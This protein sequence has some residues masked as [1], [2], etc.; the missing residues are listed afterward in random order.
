MPVSWRHRAAA[1]A[2]TLG[3]D[4]RTLEVTV[5]V[6]DPGAFT[7]RWSARQTYNLEFQGP[8][9][10][11]PCAKNNANYFGFDVSALPEAKTPDF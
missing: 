3:Q 5:T 4:G 10:E 6:E 1:G 8:W 9:D 7:T 2:F 11:S